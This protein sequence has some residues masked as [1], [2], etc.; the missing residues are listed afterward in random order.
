MSKI[1]ADFDFANFWN[2][3]EY[4]LENYVN[5]PLTENLLKEVQADLP[6]KIPQSYIEFM[7]YQN[8]GQPFNTCYPTN[9]PTLWADD[10][11]AV[12]AIAGISKK[13]IN[14]L[15]GEYGSQCMIDN[16]YPDIG[17]YFAGCPS[18]HAMFAFDY[19]ECGKD[20]EPS[21]VYVAQEDDFE[22]TFLAKDFATF[23]KGLKSEDEFIND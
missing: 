2:N 4:A 14:S 19:T 13:D 11:V 5:E 3:S 21:V 9:T 1:F 16:G 7:K 8:G 12:D 17:I 22:I 18:G 6:Y 10:H 20:G 15:G 23:I